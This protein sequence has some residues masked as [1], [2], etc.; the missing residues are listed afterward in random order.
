MKMNIL[1]VVIIGL[2]T[3]IGG[4]LSEY[5]IQRGL[6]PKTEITYNIQDV[7]SK[8]DVIVSSSQG[9]TTIIVTVSGQTNSKFYNWQVNSHTNIS[10]TRSIM[11]NKTLK[12]NADKTLKSLNLPKLFIP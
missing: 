1:A 4:M 8:T 9:Q 11:T 5:G 6:P 7:K 10:F 12:S 2:V 3:F